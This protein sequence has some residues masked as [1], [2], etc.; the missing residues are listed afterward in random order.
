ME[1]M[2]LT[3]MEV[4]EAL[5][6]GRSKVYALIASGALPSVRIGRRAVRVPAQALNAWVTGIAPKAQTRE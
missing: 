3:P 5:G 6:L 2:L 1:K 4:G